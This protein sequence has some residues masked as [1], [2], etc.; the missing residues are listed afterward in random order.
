MYVAK[1]MPNC[2]HL[3]IKELARRTFKNVSLLSNNCIKKSPFNYK[4]Y[5]LPAP[6]SRIIIV[7]LDYLTT[8]IIRVISCASGY[9]GD[10]P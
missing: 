9:G 1:R 6:F 7:Y 10:V 2:K 3:K 5:S 8:K 4:C